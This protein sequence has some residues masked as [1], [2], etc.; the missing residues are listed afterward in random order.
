[1][2]NINLLKCMSIK[3][4]KSSIQCTRNRINNTEYCGYHNRAKNITRVD[5]LLIK[6]NKIAHSNIKIID[7][8]TTIKNNITK[9]IYDYSDI[10]NCNNITNLTVQNLK[11][12]IKMLNSINISPLIDKTKRGM[13]NNLLYYYQTM[14]YYNKKI[15]KITIVQRYIK[16]Y[17]YKKRLKCINEYDL[18]TIESKMDIP[19]YYYFDMTDENKNTYFFDIRTFNKILLDNN[20]TN[21]YTLLPI[22]KDIIHNFTKK[23]NYLL[24]R[25]LSFNFEKDKISTEQEFTHRMVDIFHKFDMLDNY[26]DHRWFENLNLNQLKRLYKKAE[27]IWNYRSQLTIEQKKR[28]V[29]SGKAFDISMEYIYHINN[30]QKRKLQNI[31]L[32]EFERFSTEGQDINEKKLGTMLILTALVEVSPEAANGLP[33]LVQYVE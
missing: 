15:N 11:Y 31:I 28:I 2:L 8:D 25:G 29:S 12:T 18:Y 26:T 23:K 33:H 27:D 7:K 20:P 4:K 22:S 19:L 9:K 16:Q 14:D 21:P 30:K 10:I 32:N 3:N 13:Y 24:K 6:N 17:F 1:M 5:N